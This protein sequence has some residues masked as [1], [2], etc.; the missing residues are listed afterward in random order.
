MLGES[1]EHPESE[2][3]KQPAEVLTSTDQRGEY[4]GGESGDSETDQDC[5]VNTSSF[6]MIIM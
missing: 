3:C 4:S 2:S 6:S 1:A 5:A